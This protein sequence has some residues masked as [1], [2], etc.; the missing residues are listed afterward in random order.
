MV[1]GDRRSRA[2]QSRGIDTEESASSQDRNLGCIFQVTPKIEITPQ[3]S[4]PILTKHCS[5]QGLPRSHLQ[6]KNCLQRKMLP[7][8]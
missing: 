4:E 6:A 8:L 3:N 2:V 5:P 7:V 1:K